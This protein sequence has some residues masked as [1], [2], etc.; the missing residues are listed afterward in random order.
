MLLSYIPPCF[1]IV[2]AQKKRPADLIIRRASLPA[3]DILM[4][5]KMLRK[6]EVTTISIR[7]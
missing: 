4:D 2:A 5:F 1:I 6:F 7:K 3:L